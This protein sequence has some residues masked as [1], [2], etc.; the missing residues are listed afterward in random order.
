MRRLTTRAVFGGALFLLL[1]STLQLAAQ[2][3]Q[4][5]LYCQPS[6]EV[7]P[8]GGGCKLSNNI[9]VPFDPNATGG[10]PAFGPGACGMHP[11]GTN[12]T[13]AAGQC[14]GPATTQC[15]AQAA[16]KQGWTYQYNVV[17]DQPPNPCQCKISPKIVGGVH[18]KAAPYNVWD[19]ATKP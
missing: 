8:A 6:H 9:C 5:N 1:L 13:Q 11:S 7:L 19:C 12:S 17:C 4:P 18:A 15:L 10:N 16:N 14:M 3:Y 2:Q